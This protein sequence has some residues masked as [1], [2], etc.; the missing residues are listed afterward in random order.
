MIINKNIFAIIIDNTA[1]NKW[2]NKVKRINNEYHHYFVWYSFRVSGISINDSNYQILRCSNNLIYSYRDIRSY[3]IRYNYIN[4]HCITYCCVCRN[5]H[6]KSILYDRVEIEVPN[7][8]HYSSGL[9]HPNGY[10]KS[11]IDE[12]KKNE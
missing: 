4:N 12:M 6:P 8:Y 3:S 7:N 2:K 1:L 11:F 10:K 5:N 9:N